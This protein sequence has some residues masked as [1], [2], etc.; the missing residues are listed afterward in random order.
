MSRILA[1]DIGKFKSVTRLLDS[2]TN[3]TEFWSMSTDPILC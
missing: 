1:K 3:Q 2:E